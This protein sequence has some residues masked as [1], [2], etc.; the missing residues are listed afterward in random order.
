MLHAHIMV[1]MIK[2]LI[3]KGI[4]FWR[5]NSEPIGPLRLILIGFRY[6]ILKS[7]R[8]E[9]QPMSTNL[10]KQTLILTKRK[11]K[12]KENKL[13]GLAYMKS[14]KKIESASQSKQTNQLKEKVLYFTSL[15]LLFSTG[16]RN[17]YLC[18]DVKRKSKLFSYEIYNNISHKGQ[19]IKSPTITKSFHSIVVYCFFFV[20]EFTVVSC[21]TKR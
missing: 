19:L 20:K 21:K 9:S 6:N 8:R 1:V 14:L 5:K 12:K 3:L 2:H 4:F 15:D 16:K 13:K 10:F 18:C 7:E 11:Q 17:L